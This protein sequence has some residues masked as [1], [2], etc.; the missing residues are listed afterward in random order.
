M[1]VRLL[2]LFILVAVPAL[3]LKVDDLRRDVWGPGIAEAQEQAPA[4]QLDQEARGPAMDPPPTDQPGTDAGA[5]ASGQAAASDPEESATRADPFSLTD[6]EIE[7]LQKLAR[8]RAEIEREVA[9]LE[10]RKIVMEAAEGRVDG[11]L[12]EL[13]ALQEMIQDLLIKHDDQEESQM[14][15]LV[16]I[17]ESMKP[18]DAARIFEQ[19][20]MVV[21]LDVIGRMKER[22]SAPILAMMDPERAKSVTLE[23]ASRRSL[24]IPR[25]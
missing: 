11:K 24:P 10:Q 7:L 23:L 13:K 18:K 3:T 4:P 1:R 22:K 6:E 21:L 20:D 25:N 17:Y 14:Q 19:L 16:K 8:R 15:S 2:P 9:V 5:M 12:E